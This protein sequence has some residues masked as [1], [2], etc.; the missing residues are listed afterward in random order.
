VDQD[1]Q[2]PDDSPTETTFTVD[3]HSEMGRTRNPAVNIKVGTFD[4]ASLLPLELGQVKEQGDDEFTTVTTEPGFTVEWIEAHLDEQARESWWQEACTEGVQDARLLAEELLGARQVYTEGRSGGWLTVQDLPEV[5][6]WTPQ[7][8]AAWVEFARQVRVLADETPRRYLW[9]LNA[10]A[11]EPWAERLE[12]LRGA[13]PADF[14]VKVLVTGDVLLASDPAKDPVTC[15]TCHRTWDDAIPTAYTP[16]PAG[17][18]PF[19]AWHGEPALSP[20][21]ELAAARQEIIAAQAGLDRAVR[22]MIE[23]QVRVAYPTAVRL[24]AYG[25]YN[26]A[27]ILRAYAERVVDGAGTVLASRDDPTEEWGALTD[28]IDDLLCELSEHDEDYQGDTDIDFGPV[29]QRLDD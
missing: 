21:E 17:R 5:E 2:T 4:L 29:P 27:G 19:E 22:R 20:A 11:Y 6:E 10:N 28:E 15:G 3:M 26:E 9:L 24:V 7:Q 18:C 23:A 16:A 8:R 14:P 13:V 12:E 1:Q 25:E